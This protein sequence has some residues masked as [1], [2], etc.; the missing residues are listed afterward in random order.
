MM[1]EPLS[2]SRLLFFRIPRSGARRSGATQRPSSAYGSN[3]EVEEL[4][5]L[6]ANLIERFVRGASQNVPLARQVLKIGDYVL[7]MYGW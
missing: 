1:L 4:D 5:R 3:N 7:R 6:L 2:M